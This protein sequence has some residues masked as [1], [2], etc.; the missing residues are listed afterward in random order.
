MQKTLEILQKYWGY[1]SFRP[2]QDEVVQ[3]VLEGHDTFALLPTGGGKSLC[4]QVP[5]MISGGLCLVVSPLVALMK[6]QVGQ[7]Q[8]RGIKAIALTGGTHA[9]ELIQLLDNCQ[10]G[11]Y[12]FLYLSPERLEQDWVLER[13]KSLPI[14][15]IA[16]DEAHCVSQWGYDF[17]PSYLKI[18]TL[19][20][21]FP[22]VPF[23]ALTASAT[24]EVQQDILL[25]LGLINPKIFK[26]SF[27]RDNLS[28]H[29]I[30]SE[31]KLYKIK[32]ILLKN[33][34]P[35]I[36]YVRNRKLC[37]DYANQ[38]NSLGFSATYYHGG[39][40]PKDKEKN[41]ESWMNESRLIMVAT[42][43]FG[44]GIDKPNVKTVIHVN[45]PENL[46]SY[47]QEAGRAGRAGQKAFA[48]MIASYNDIIHAQEQ[49]VTVLPDVV[50]LKEIYK[51]LCN[52]FQIPY[53]EGINEEF[54][55]SLNRFCTHYN[56]PIL[57]TFNALQFL[58]RQ[59]IISLSNEQSEKV[60]L[61]FI[62]ESKEV[63]RYISFHPDE[64]AIITTILRN[65]PGI[66]EIQ[67]N[68]NT[69]FVAKQAF[70]KE[71]KV[72]NLLQ[73]LKEQNMVH[74]LIIQNE[75]KITFL[76]VRED[77]R[78][79]NRI[80]K[81]LEKQNLTKKSQ[82]AA[83]V[84]YVNDQNQC[85]SKLILTYFG[86]IGVADCGSCSYCLKKNKKIY[87]KEHLTEELLKI[88]KTEKLSSREI[89]EKI[90]IEEKILFEILKE[91]LEYN[92][93]ELDHKNQFIL[94]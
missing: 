33:P 51:K 10:F 77:D 48:I 22:K 90:N 61:Q 60:Q 43:A 45:L 44:M 70:C 3:S 18:N 93:I 38:L 72:F 13:I 31:D 66:F 54:T 89:L 94:K 58:D 37:L 32:Q 84:A 20:K 50:F 28:Y 79:I 29:V 39:L 52:Y 86:E 87:N 74:L 26:K 56:F 88:L 5:A 91:M 57:K 41:M 83:V 1:D 7:L 49:F 64:E 24:P 85:K 63:I 15:L 21:A 4:F 62:V 34:E 30:K 14:H 23:I 17:R 47:Y 65:Y 71:E 8:K 53:G 27:S 67:T 25:N 81:Y 76:E 59:G 46:E 75:S 2:V 69:S 11:N 68:I 16:V 6:D 36:I 40:L 73:K 19:K 9:D 80:A 92:M 82:L 12:H 78:T 42:N 35:S 55:F